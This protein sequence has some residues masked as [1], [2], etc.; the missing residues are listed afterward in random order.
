M[1]SPDFAAAA[2][3]AVVL[4]PAPINPEWIV[5]GAPLA[6]SV[7]IFRSPD[8][9]ATCNVWDCTAGTFKWYFGVDE[10][11]HILQGE[12]E[13]TAQDGSVRVLKPGEVA[14]FASGTWATWRIENYVRKLAY[15]RHS[16]P[17]LLA[18]SLRAIGKLMR[19]SG[20]KSAAPDSGLGGNKVA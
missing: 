10:T 13:V 4:E 8:G 3:D 20:L 7:E 18:Y 19:M 2:L 12:V 15:C 6:R 14:F 5:T 11:V 16:M 1:S 9:A 17:L